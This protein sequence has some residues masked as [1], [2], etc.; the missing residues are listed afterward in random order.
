MFIELLT[1]GHFSRRHLVRSYLGRNHDP[2]D[3]RWRE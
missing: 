3:V 1:L 2:S